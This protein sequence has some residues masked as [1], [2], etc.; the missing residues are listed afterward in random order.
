MQ[1]SAA[2]RPTLAG[3]A[4]AARYDWSNVAAEIMAVY[5]TVATGEKVRVA[6]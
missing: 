3:A 1:P 6:K 4:R 5:E 2:S